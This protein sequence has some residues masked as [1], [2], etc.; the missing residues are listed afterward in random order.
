MP[1]FG[2]ISQIMEDEEFEEEKTDTMS[3]TDG[4]RMFP[5]PIIDIVDTMDSTVATITPNQNPEWFSVRVNPFHPS[6]FVAE[7]EI[8]WVDRWGGEMQTFRERRV[9]HRPY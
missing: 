7:R 8:P 1:I 3:I 9:I 5:V 4:I 6:A 2:I